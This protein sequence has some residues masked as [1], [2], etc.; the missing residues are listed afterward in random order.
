MIETQSDMPT[1]EA[2]RA[3]FTKRR[4]FSGQREYRFAVRVA[5]RPLRQAI[6]LEMST[7]L[8][9]LTRRL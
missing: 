3:C 1:M 5:G 9:R 2:L 7:E 6:Y 8:L 4:E